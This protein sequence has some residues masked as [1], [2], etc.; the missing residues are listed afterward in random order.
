MNRNLIALD[1]GRRRVGV[2]GCGGEVSLAFGITTLTI[3]GLKDLLAQLNPILKERHCREILIGFPLT[4][5]NKPGPLA[6]EILSLARQLE[7]EGL[8]VHLV[9][10][11]LSSRR[12]AGILRQ[13]GK[14]A[15]K[16]DCDRTSAAL[17]LQEYLDGLLPPISCAEISR[18]QLKNSEED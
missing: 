7:A 14:R 15:R 1:Y 12:A 2:A 18:L 10:E 9:D 8:T 11:A 13:R 4:L 17:L 16:G 5:G 6:P 3:R